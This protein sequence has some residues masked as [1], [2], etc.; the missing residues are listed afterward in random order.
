MA[1]SFDEFLS[2]LPKSIKENYSTEDLKKAYINQ[3]A[4]F[5]SNHCEA[6]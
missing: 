4:S 1:R 2:R 3:M 5:R 6:A